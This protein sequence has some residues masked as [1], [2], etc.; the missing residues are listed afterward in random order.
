[1]RPR[2]RRFTHVRYNL[3]LMRKYLTTTTVPTVIA[4]TANHRWILTKPSL[5]TAHIA[6]S[7][8][9]NIIRNMP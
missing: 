2:F 6:R 4:T 5:L 1:M 9:P 3:P 8:K 7:P